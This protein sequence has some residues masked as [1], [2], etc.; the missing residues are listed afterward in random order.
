[1]AG[2]I[3]AQPWFRPEAPRDCI[4]G[5]GGTEGKP[6]KPQG[7]HSRGFPKRERGMRGMFVEPQQTSIFYF[8]VSKT[9]QNKSGR[10]R[11]PN[12]SDF[13][14]LCLSS[15]LSLSKLQCRPQLNALGSI[16][17][18]VL[19]FQSLKFAGKYLGWGFHG[20]PFG[21]KPFLILEKKHV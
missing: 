15:K 10:G 11:F 1:M 14:V 16:S 18:M 6:K 7:N 12:N 8:L 2:L 13:G 19:S 4:F 17:S 5:G 21:D 3:E 9:Q 20:I